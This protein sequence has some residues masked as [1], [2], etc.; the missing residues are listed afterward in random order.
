MHCR[1]ELTGLLR[2]LSQCPGYP[3]QDLLGLALARLAMTLQR[4]CRADR[5]RTHTVDDAGAGCR[6]QGLFAVCLITVRWVYAGA[7]APFIG[8]L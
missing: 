7:F 5:L 1:L 8:R 6:S 3:R 4:Q 2:I